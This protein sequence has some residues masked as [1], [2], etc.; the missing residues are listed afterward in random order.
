MIQL[1]TADEE[2][3]VLI[4]TDVASGQANGFSFQNVGG[5]WTL[6]VLK[7]GWMIAA[8]GKINVGVWMVEL[9]NSAGTLGRLRLRVNI[10]TPSSQL[11]MPDRNTA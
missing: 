11:R 3:R 7:P 6:R 8:G 10:A 2:M 9:C 5:G 1:L 4:E